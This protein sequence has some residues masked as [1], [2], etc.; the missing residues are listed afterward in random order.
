MWDFE[1]V[2]ESHKNKWG[3]KSS[4]GFYIGY[5]Y[6]IEYS[7]K[8][9][10]GRQDNE[11][12]AHTVGPIPHY[13]NRGSIGICLQGNTN[14]KAPTK[15]QLKSLAVLIDKKKR[16]YSI[17]NDKVLGH[18]EVAATECPGMNLWHWLIRNYP[19]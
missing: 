3:F 18:K 13:Y 2:N 10:Q 1:R 7:G 16:Q 8:V 17:A 6:F 4:L 11:E 5:H 14:N 9:Y 12:G 15:E 19:S